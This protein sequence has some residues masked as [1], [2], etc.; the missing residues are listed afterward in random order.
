MDAFEL[1]LGL[2]LD[3]SDSATGGAGALSA[4]SGKSG[5][6]GLY[7]LPRKGGTKNGFGVFASDGAAD[8]LT[9]SL[10]WSAGGGDLAAAIAAARLSSIVA[11]ISLFASPSSMCSPRPVPTGLLW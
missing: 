1:P 9:R 6:T 10:N 4:A 7:G 2:R 11:C 3:R 5:I 8:F